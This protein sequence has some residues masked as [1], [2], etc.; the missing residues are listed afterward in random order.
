MLCLASSSVSSAAN[1]VLPEYERVRVLSTARPI[2][3]IELVDKSGSP[4]AL[5]ELRG[6]VVM[7]FFGFANCPDV[8]P[9]TMARLQQF[10][11]S[12]GKDLDDVVYAMISVDGE[13]D[14][15]EK[16][17]K[18]VDGFSPEFIGLTG[19][20]DLVKRVA[21]EFRAPFYKGNISGPSNAYS[22]AHAP[23]VF[24][25][26]ADGMLRAELYN[27]SFEAM[28][29]ISKALLDEHQVSQQRTTA[30]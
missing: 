25:L 1:N 12:A 14:T 19:K 18:F 6:R 13:R 8:C 4:F 5:R 24:L 10:K 20:P 16:L 29:G 11:Q 7:V 3:E 15:P 2:S 9:T 26:D 27:A 21:A 23:Q 30:D 28:A 17:K 22:V